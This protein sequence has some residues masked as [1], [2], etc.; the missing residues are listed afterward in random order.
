MAPDRIRRRAHVLERSWDAASAFARRS[1]GSP[2]RSLVMPTG[3]RR[4][5]LVRTMDAPSD[6]SGVSAPR[7]SPRRRAATGGAKP[8]SDDLPALGRLERDPVPASPPSR[9]RLRAPC[10]RRALRGHRGYVAVFASIAFD[11]DVFGF[12]EIE[13]NLFL[14]AARSPYSTGFRTLLWTV[15]YNHHEALS[16]PRPA[17]VIYDW[18]DDLAIFTEFDARLVRRNHERALQEADVVTSVARTLHARAMAQRT[19]AVYLPNGVDEEHFR[20]RRRTD[21][22]R[23]TIARLRRAG[24]PLA[25]DGGGS[26]RPDRRPAPP[27]REAHRRIL[28]GA[29][30]VVQRLR[31]ARQTARRRLDWN[32]LLIGPDYDGSLRRASLLRCPNVVWLGPRPYASLPAYLR[33]FDV[34]TIPFRLDP[35]T[36]ATSPLKLYEYFAGCRPVVTTAMPECVAHAEVRVVADGRRVRARPRRRPTRGRGSG[37]TRTA[38]RGGA[39]NSWGSESQIEAVLGR[40][41]ELLARARPSDRAGARLA[42][43][44]HRSGILTSAGRRLARTGGLSAR[45]RG[46]SRTRTGLAHAC[47][48]ERSWPRHRRSPP[49][50]GGWPPA[51]ASVAE[52]AVPGEGLRIPPPSPPRPRP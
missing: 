16:F 21:A 31:A 49:E 34:A 7:A 50:R 24:Q 14:F 12:E 29:R 35:I 8:G 19:D 37:R 23:P 11:D 51:A 10:G 4:Q 39:A 44:V 42:P 41:R 17:T 46:R 52:S 25:G 6:G 38:A 45:R 48:G 1:H 40:G 9:P 26:G 27:R 20:R 43:D 30:P 32:F 2:W 28:R 15:A 5:W 22:G 47:G 3:S 36:L 33:V 18:I 13:P